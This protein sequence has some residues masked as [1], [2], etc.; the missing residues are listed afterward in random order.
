MF[1]KRIEINY[2]VIV[3]IAYG[4]M[5]MPIFLFMLGWLKLAIGLVAITLLTIGYISLMKKHY[6]DTEKFEMEIGAIFVLVAFVMVWVYTSGVGGFWAQREDWLWRNAVLRDLEEYTWP[7]VY[8]KTGGMLVYYFNY[9]LPAALIGKFFGFQAGNV[10]LYVYTVIGIGIALLL[11]SKIVR[12]ISTSQMLFL[13]FLF[14]IWHGTNGALDG[15]L[16]YQF[17]SNYTL[18]QWVT[19]QTIIPWIAAALVL[20]KREVGTFLFVGMCVF[21]SAPFPFVGF[22][23]LLL[24]EGISQIYMRYNGLFKEWIFQVLSIPNI[25]ALFCI[26][27]CYSLFFCMNTAANG[28][29]GAGGFGFLVPLSEL[30]F[31]QGIALLLTVFTS[32]WIYSIIIYRNYFKDAVFWTINICA[33]LLPLFKLGISTDFGM[34]SIIPLQFILMI[35]VADYAIERVEDCLNVKRLV[36]VI[37]LIICASSVIKEWMGQYQR[38]LN[39][40][41]QQDIL[42]VGIDSFSNKINEASYGGIPPINFICNFAKDF[43]IFSIICKNKSEEQ[44][45][46]DLK[47]SDNFLSEKNFQIISGEYRISPITVQESFVISDDALRIGDDVSVKPIVIS[48]STVDSKYEL[49]NFNGTEMWSFSY[50]DG[51]SMVNAPGTQKFGDPRIDET[52]LFELKQEDDGYMII[53]N[54]EYAMTYR[55]EEISWD[56][57]T[58]S[59]NQ[60]WK[61]VKMN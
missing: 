51:F 41:S 34:R 27:S 47:K 15:I 33:I 60:I 12:V 4:Y 58:V 7:V 52:Q 55:N 17:S 42:A 29:S 37:S 32:I 40:Q 54:N 21:A 10:A 13:C 30:T 31:K 24:V 5:L 43:S 8:P 44:S 50:E 61:I 39:A 53:W 46:R 25:I 1:C 14:F 28:K 48:D 23:I 49:Y 3:W 57:I 26:F 6:Y 22:C 59:K 19:N 35:F 2:N 36:L 9:F 20:G 56:K 45:I 11:I 38:V 18:L 16:Y